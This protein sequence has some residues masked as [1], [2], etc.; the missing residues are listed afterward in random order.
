MVDYELCDHKPSGNVI[1]TGPGA[2]NFRLMAD[3]QDAAVCQGS[4]LAIMLAL[5]RHVRDGGNT[6]FPSIETLGH[7]AG[8]MGRRG[9]QKVLERLEGQ[10]LIVRRETDRGRAQSSVYVLN[11]KLI[12]ARA[13]DGRVARAARKSRTAG[14]LSDAERANADSPFDKER[15]NTSSPICDEGANAGSPIERGK[16]ERAFHKGRTLVPERAN[17]R[18]PEHSNEHRTEHLESPLSEMCGP[19]RDG[20]CPQEFQLASPDTEPDPVVRAVE[21]WNDLA[22]RQHVSRV[23]KITQKRRKAIAARL[24]DL[25]GIDGWKIYLGKIEA[26]DWLC[27]RKPGKDWPTD[28]DFI[29]REDQ[30]VRIMERDTR[31]GKHQHQAGVVPSSWGQSLTGFAGAA[32]RRRIAREQ[33]HEGEV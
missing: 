3:V 30:M 26:D 22:T 13:E 9:V 12:E 20:D 23:Q 28:L 11:V 15:A 24:G 25:A 1:T 5:A 27:G 7:L 16:G 4:E 32:M 2:V 19:G 21:L 10:G 31:N 17:Q 6:C 29:L 14:H 18:S 33:G 8:G